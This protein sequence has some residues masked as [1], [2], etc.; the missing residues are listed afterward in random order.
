[1]RHLLDCFADESLDQQCFGFL[2]VD[3]ARHQ[4]ELEPVIERAG[5][6]AMAADHV[7]GEDFELRLVVGS[8]SSE[9][10]SARVI[11]LALVFC[12]CGCTTILPW[13]TLWL[14]SSSTARNCSRLSQCPAACSISN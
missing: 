7:V 3:A 2:L 5:G 10:R 11:I 12:A 6:G 8:A 14:S 1:M 9:S 4:I 13:N